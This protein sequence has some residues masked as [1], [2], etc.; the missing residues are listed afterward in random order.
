MLAISSQEEMGG[1]LEGRFPEV[2]GQGNTTF[3]S[4]WLEYELRK[5][6]TAWSSWYSDRC[7]RL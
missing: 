2:P 4:A 7:F 6:G 5:L 3:L 1:V